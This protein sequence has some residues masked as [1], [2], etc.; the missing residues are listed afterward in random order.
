MYCLWQN[1]YAGCHS[2]LRPWVFCTKRAF[3]KNALK[4]SSAPLTL[5]STKGENANKFYEV[6]WFIDHN[7][8][9]SADCKNTPEKNL[10][11]AYSIGQT[12][13]SETKQMQLNGN[14][15]TFRNF[16]AS[17]NWQFAT[18][19]LCISS[20]QDSSQPSKSSLKRIPWIIQQH[21]LFL[22]QS[23]LMESGRWACV[24]ATGCCSRELQDHLV[25][26]WRQRHPI[27]EPRKQPYELQQA[28]NL[29]TGTAMATRTKGLGLAWVPKRSQF[30]CYLPVK[31]GHLIMMDK[32]NSL[33]SILRN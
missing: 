10:K 4:I 23:Q 28:W 8:I 1:C 30:F 20:Y 25:A 19:K 11:T 33:F 22:Q 24:T 16:S 14:T 18:S 21:F 29:P 3:K 15:L 2:W 12:R 26:T 27:T 6:Y 9:E 13:E 32:W 31:L 7:V 5:P 17:D